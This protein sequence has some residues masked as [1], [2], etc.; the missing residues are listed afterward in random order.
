[1]TG[2][3]GVDLAAEPKGTAVARIQWSSGVARVSNLKC[4]A[5]DETVLKTIQ[6]GDLVGVDCALGWP[7]PFVDFVSRHR[8]GR[9]RVEDG[10]GANWRRRLTNRTTDLACVEYTRDHAD[11]IVRPLSVSADLLGHTALRAAVLLAGLEADV[12]VDRSGESGS[13]AEVYPAA[14]LALWRIEPRSYKGANRH[15]LNEVVDA[16]LAAASWLDLGEHQEQVR[17][18]DHCFD[19]VVAALGARAV[20]IERSTGPTRDQLEIAQR[21]GWIRLPTCA[22]ADLATPP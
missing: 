4:P 10:A 7:D 13:L 16:L 20:Q 14:C 21:E 8:A 5:D 2:T 18:S 3:V 22:L 1:M 11:R 15:R 12:V 19:A 9:I 6:A 17:T